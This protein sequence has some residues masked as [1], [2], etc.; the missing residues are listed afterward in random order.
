MS[1]SRSRV[2]VALTIAGACALLASRAEGQD[3][4]DLTT[5]G[6]AKDILPRYVVPESPAATFLSAS[7]AKATRPASA[8]DLGAAL[9]NAIDSKGR[10][11]QGVS[12]EAAY[13][14]LVG[15]NISLSDYQNRRP[16]F[17]LA[18]TQLSISSVRASGDT[19]STDLAAG[20][21]TTFFDHS[22]PLASRELTAALAK[23][24]RPCLD[25]LPVLHADSLRFFMGDTAKP[26][27]RALRQ[28]DSARAVADDSSRRAE[29]AAKE[30]K[31]AEKSVE[32]LKR[33]F[34]EEHW[35]GS[36]LVLAYA[37]G[38]RLKNSRVGDRADRGQRLWGTA[39]LP[40]GRRAQLVAYADW[41]RAVAQD[42]VPGYSAVGYGG[43]LVVGAP[44]FNF[45]AERRRERRNREAPGL[46]RQVDP[47]AGGIE[48]R[49]APELW[50]SAGLG[51]N[52]D[53]DPDPKSG[54][55][56]LANLRW[57]ISDRPRVAPASLR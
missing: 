32:S 42:T 1:R 6:A 31:C 51:A 12:I 34:V 13:T 57:G 11:Q 41:T 44:D 14:R 30:R 48:F 7:P 16:R 47:W 40:L 52:A 49:I 43:R 35:N 19:A 46:T 45:F 24:A 37:Q 28:L 25:T 36:S 2:L 55:V 10:L 17:A 23:A 50:I 5:A 15:E 39:S 54:T 56:V 20:I 26:A 22:D 53:N 18:N 38:W 33:K 3:A 9:I 21:R 4:V 27:E 29:S 8:K